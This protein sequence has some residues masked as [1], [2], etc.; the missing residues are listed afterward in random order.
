M[1]ELEKRYELLAARRT[2]VMEVEQGGARAV[3][4][5]DILSGQGAQR[6]AV[7]AYC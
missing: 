3:G 5:F 6:Q 4:W 1:D 7:W 2:S